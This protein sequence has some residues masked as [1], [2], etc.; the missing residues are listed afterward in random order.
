[1]KISRIFAG[2]S[3]LALAASMT[4]IN[5]FAESEAAEPIDI[6]E[7][8]ATLKNY[9]DTSLKFSTDM[10]LESFVFPFNEDKG[11]GA[12]I[13]NTDESHVTL[14]IEELAGIPM[15]RVQTL[16]WNDASDPAGW[17][18]PKIHFDMAKLFEGMTDKL[19][20]IFTIKIDF[21]TKAVGEFTNE[22]GESSMVPGNFIG[23]VNVQKWDAETGTQAWDETG[24]YQEA[25]WTSEWGSYEVVV[26]NGLRDGS[27]W[28]DTTEQ[29]F[30]SIMKWGMPNQADYYIADIKFEDEYGDT[31]PV[32]LDALKG[33]SSET[34]TDSGSETPSGDNSS[35]PDGKTPTD[36]TTPAADGTTPDASGSGDS[37]SGDATKT[38]DT[39]SSDTKSTDS[40][41]D[42]KSGSNSTTTT[43][44][45]STTKTTASGGAAGTA[46][47]DS[48]TKTSDATD[49]DNTNSPTGATAGLA[50]A[51]IAVAGTIAIASKRR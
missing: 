27:T 20:E 13:P 31:I 17:G 14:S 22:E 7:M 28:V 32:N 51:G 5:V 46:S 38:D 6:S 35:T 41:T 49:A 48:A 11:N 45:T 30:L 47:T 44:T 40:K 39:K 9:N 25:E 43:G 34:P 10:N 24:S 19:P 23:S 26:R 21:V 33:G 3:A 2:M 37:K 1:M 29:Q 36:G 12:Y 42:S 50:L 16:D 4:A 18:I 8:P 15:L